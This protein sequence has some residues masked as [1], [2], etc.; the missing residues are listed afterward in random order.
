MQG[1][2][3]TIHTFVSLLLVMVILMQASQGGGLSGT[4]GSGATS[5]HGRQGRS[6][7]IKQTYHMAGYYIHD[8]GFVNQ[9]FQF[10]LSC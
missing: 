9:F 10:T 6:F 2:L 8:V 7:I 5:D 1:F 4:F 3:I